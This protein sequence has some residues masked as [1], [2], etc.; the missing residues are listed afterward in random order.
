MQKY[1]VLF[2]LVCCL[3]ACTK[4]ID[5]DYNEIDAVVVVEGRVTNEGTYVLVTKSRSM[6]D[7]VKSPCLPGAVVTI[8]ADGVNESIAYDPQTHCYHSD[9]KGQAGVTYK[10]TVDF[11]GK[12]YEGISTMPPAAPVLSAEFIWFDV[13]D[14]R[15]VVFEIW[16]TD[17]VSTERN[18]YWYRMDRITQ[19]PHFEGRS[20]TEPYR[21]SVFDNRGNPPG[22][23]Y[24][25][26]ICMSERMAEEDEEENWDR[27]LYEGDIITF[28]LMSIDRSTYDYFSSLRAGQ[29]GGA[30][31]KSNLTGGCTGYF[32]AGSITRSETMVFRYDAIHTE[33]P[34][35]IW[36]QYTKT[37]TQ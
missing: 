18:Y 22:L 16:A 1:L 6:T 7:S 10:L 23:I 11:E 12:H 30:N 21:W 24:R 35:T 19:H 4:E 26:I 29:G 3:T 15:M 33:S 9:F 8:T 20:K 14:E 27:I 13:L 37:H 36:N 28:Q 2:I 31:P 5:F 17:P 34:S 32:T 25:D